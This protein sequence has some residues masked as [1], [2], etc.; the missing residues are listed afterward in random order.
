MYQK[1]HESAGSGKTLPSRHCLFW[2]RPPPLVSPTL[3]YVHEKRAWYPKSH[4]IRNDTAQCFQRHKVLWK[5]KFKEEGEKINKI[6]PLY[7]QM[8]SIF[9]LEMHS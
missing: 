8:S 3:L 7:I 5:I 1:A 2:P 6:K 4:D 9:F